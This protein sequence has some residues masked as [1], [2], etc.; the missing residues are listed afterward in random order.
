[1][2]SAST[3]STVTPFEEIPREDWARLSLQTPLPLSEEDVTRLRGLGD[4]IDLKTMLGLEF[5]MFLDAIGRHAE[6]DS[7]CLLELSPACGKVDRF[8]GTTA[9]VIFGVE[10]EYDFLA[11][12]LG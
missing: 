5:V 12:Q 2:K 1:M 3:S 11:L 6:D 4:K 8:G 10:I 7:T 9:G